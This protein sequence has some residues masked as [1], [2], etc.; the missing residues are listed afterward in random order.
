[1]ADDRAATLADD[2]RLY[3]KEEG[4]LP[5]GVT[6]HVEYAKT[7]TGI[8]PLFAGIKIV[9]CDTHFTEPPDLFTAR[10]SAK[11][12][13]RMP[14][15]RRVGQVDRWFIGDRDFG[16]MG[17]NVIG[18]DANK[19]LGRLA[20]PTLDEGAAGSYQVKPRLKAMDDMGVYA[21]ITYQN[22]GITQ[23][24]S[25]MSLNDNELA[26]E[27][28]K[29]YNDGNA[30]RQQE[31]GQR[32]FGLAHLPLWDR[33]A[34]EAEA[35]RCLDMDIKGFIL[36]DRP[37]RLGLPS[38]DDAYWSAFFEMCEAS[39]APLNFHLN[40]AMDPDALRWASFDFEQSLTVTAL[41]MSI[42]NA[43]TLA[44]WMV[45][46]LLDRHP[47]LKIGLIESGVGW[48]P[49]ALEML[50][51]QFDETLPKRAAKMERRPW[52]YFRQ[53]FWV[54]YWFETLAPQ[55]FLDVLGVDRVLFETDY[56]HPTS[57]YPGVQ[58]HLVETLGGHDYAVRKRVLQSNAVEL[59]NLPF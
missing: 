53:N 17:G 2:A 44:N 37:E 32:L 27:I 20:F 16:T 59:Y 56:P 47:K 7:F 51:H 28:L 24:G 39:G 43:A 14:H 46:G 55:K 42:G 23:A 29:I 45:S 41:M 25:L 49:F 12:K 33:A 54:T 15:R 21:Q 40:S 11:F 4:H 30:E 36:P 50:E 8:D 58:Q 35:R 10:A 26:V 57:L 1:M 34:L 9:D 3:W 52:E 38:F 6:R 13:D 31:S 48:V 18:K 22:S 19:L 5:G